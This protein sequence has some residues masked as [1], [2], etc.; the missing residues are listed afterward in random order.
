MNGPSMNRYFQLNA[1]IDITHKD[2]VMHKLDDVL[3]WIT[4]CLNCN[5]NFAEVTILQPVE[6][7]GWPDFL[8]APGFGPEHP[9]YP[10]AIEILEKVNHWLTLDRQQL[11]S[12]LQQQYNDAHSEKLRQ[13]RVDEENALN[14]KKA[15]ALDRVMKQLSDAGFDVDEAINGGDCVELVDGIYKNLLIQFPR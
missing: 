9:D 4:A 2:G 8:D 5:T 7:L 3:A 12:E 15:K 11:I 14:A 1:T 6:R 10:Y 13:K